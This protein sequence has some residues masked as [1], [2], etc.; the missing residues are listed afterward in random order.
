VSQQKFVTKITRNSRA[1]TEEA[2]E[3]FPQKC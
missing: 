1:I 2:F 3:T